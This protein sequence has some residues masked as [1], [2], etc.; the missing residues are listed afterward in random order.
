MKSHTVS[1]HTQETILHLLDDFS[2]G[3]Y[4]VMEHASLTLGVY[5]RGDKDISGEIH[6]RLI[7]N[8]SKANI[9][10]IFV[11]N[12]THRIT[13]KT[14]QHHEAFDTKSNLLIKSVLKDN[15]TFSFDGAI[16]VEKEGQKTD[17]YQRNENLILSD[18]AFAQ[19]KPSLEILA[20]DVRCT[21]GATVGNIQPEQLFYLK[22]RG[23][24]EKD[25]IKLITEGFL[26]DAI[27]KINQSSYEQ[28]IKDTVW[29]NL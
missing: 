14:L 29:Q 5:A 15:A 17:A 24:M 18:F 9:I 26:D 12:S 7:G 16:R 22:T 20:N 27:S 1:S 25:A 2:K 3:E 4:T 23:V 10:G 6:V 21:H 8:G 19:S 11:S 13:L 28:K